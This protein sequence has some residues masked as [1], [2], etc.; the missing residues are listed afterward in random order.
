M[1]MS[2]SVL[3]SS[4]PLLIGLGGLSG[5][6]SGLLGIGGGA[7]IVPALVLAL[8]MLG[9]DGEALPKIAIATSVA[10]MIPTAI[11]GA[12]HHGARGFIDGHSLALFAP[13]I[14]LGAFAAGFFAQWINTQLI[15]LLFVLYMLHIARGLAWRPSAPRV[16]AG[17]RPSLISF[18]FVGVL[19]GALSALLG[20]GSASYS[21]PFMARFTDLRIA[22]G[23][24]A[25]LNIPLAAAGVLG[26]VI[27]AAPAACG[28]ACFGYVHLPA[29]AAI[30]ISA[31][32]AA[33][34]GALLTQVLPVLLLRRLFALV[35]AVSAANLAAKTLPLAETPVYMAAAIQ[36]LQSPVR[37]AVP[38]A[39]LPPACLVDP[40]LRTAHLV[41]EYGP[42]RIFAAVQDE[43][44]PPATISAALSL[45][46]NRTEPPA[47]FWSHPV[48]KAKAVS[49]PVA[50]AAPPQPSRGERPRVTLRKPIKDIATV[51]LEVRTDPD[52]APRIDHQDAGDFD[53]FGFRSHAAPR[54][55]RQ[56]FGGDR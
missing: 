55:R 5:F 16:Q 39:A 50:V 46:R 14:V 35:L 22:I 33:P 31:V 54:P 52:P 27:S 7:V 9:V 6:L 19:G 42:Q 18:T 15:C 44:L 53:P 12:Q 38:V 34:A 43:C 20:Q 21:V 30:G 37:E 45:L 25:A 8:P 41:A 28:T 56:P 1:D 51:T 3:I 24:A 48:P 17:S 47:G 40:S 29:V 23:T 2:A 11:A 49:S 32:L 4:W 26:Y 36:R 13:S 10:I